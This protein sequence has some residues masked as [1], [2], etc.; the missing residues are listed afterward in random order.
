MAHNMH[1]WISEMDY[2]LLNGFPER[3]KDDYISHSLKLDHADGEFC[4]E[5]LLFI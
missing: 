3:L 4:I 1:H 2:A 5:P